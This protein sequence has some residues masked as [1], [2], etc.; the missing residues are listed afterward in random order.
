MGNAIDW[1][2]KQEKI[3]E[4]LSGGGTF[5]AAAEAVNV[6]REAL[7]AYWNR[8]QT[9]A[10][11]DIWLSANNL[12]DKRPKKQH[13]VSVVKAYDGIELPRWQDKRD[14]FKSGIMLGKMI[15]NYKYHE[16]GVVVGV[17]PHCFTIQTAEGIK[18]SYSYNAFMEF[19][20]EG[21]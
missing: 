12:T 18:S 19:V 13:T 21:A 15:R 9:R 10:A 2:S 14:K 4:V 16:T 5:L 6:K 20:K 7:W 8:P 3:F 1:D 11:Y 17:Y